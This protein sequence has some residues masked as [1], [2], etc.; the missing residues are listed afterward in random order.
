M[1]IFEAVKHNVSMEAVAEYCGLRPKK[2]LCLCPFHTDNRP[3]FKLYP[4]HGYCFACHT[5]ADAVQLVAYRERLTP[6]QAAR[7]LASAFGVPGDFNPY[8]ITLKTLARNQDE[9]AKK[10]VDNMRLSLTRMYRTLWQWHLTYAPKDVRALKKLDPRFQLA[11]ENMEYLEY[12]MDQCPDDLAKG[13]EWLHEVKSMQG[14]YALG[15][16]IKKL[17]EEETHENT[18]R[19]FFRKRKKL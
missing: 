3:S 6:L 19:T 12:L 16:R 17:Q 4:D 13:V 1:D 9:E 7:Q 14:L 15:D 8:V 10:A 2:G 11:I 5:R 18:H